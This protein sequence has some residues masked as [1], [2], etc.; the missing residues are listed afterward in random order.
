MKKTKTLLAIACAVAIGVALVPVANAASSQSVSATV[1]TELIALE[2]DTS[3]Y[4][5]GI[6]P[7][8]QGALSSSI[9]ATNTGNV[10]ED[11][12]ASFSDATGGEGTWTA[13]LFNGTPPFP[14]NNQFGMS[15]WDGIT[16]NWLAKTGSA[17]TTFAVNVA[18][19]GVG[20]KQFQLGLAMPNVG[21]YGGVHSWTVA[22]SAWKH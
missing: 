13:V 11:F 19:R 5:F 8:G 16:P 22:V 15:T 10:P 21:S 14:S 20:S 9:L 18:E 12:T 1:E 7:A 6:V 2:I 4:N 17:E 3:S